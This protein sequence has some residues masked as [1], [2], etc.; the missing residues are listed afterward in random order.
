MLVVQTQKGSKL[1]SLVLSPYDFSS[2][3]L[4]YYCIILYYVSG[5]I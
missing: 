5:I 2:F 3:L 4:C 1:S